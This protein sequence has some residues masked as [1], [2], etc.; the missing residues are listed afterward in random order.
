[1]VSGQAHNPAARPQAGAPTHIHCLS[2]PRALGTSP[3]ALDTPAQ[4]PS[5]VALYDAMEQEFVSEFWGLR[6]FIHVKHRENRDPPSIGSRPGWPQ[7]PRASGAESRS[8]ELLAL[9]GS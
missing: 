4:L 5:P 6:F 2:T 3:T 9:A 7:Q 1:M 8:Q